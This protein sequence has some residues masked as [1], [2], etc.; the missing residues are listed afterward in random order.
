MDDDDD[1]ILDLQASAAVEAETFLNTDFSDAEGIAQEAPAPIR[2]WIMNRI[3][4]LYEN[5]GVKVTPDFSAIQ[6]YRVYPM[7]HE[8]SEEIGS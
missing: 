2:I 8:G 3:A 6:Q 5:R 4:E 7:S 1:V